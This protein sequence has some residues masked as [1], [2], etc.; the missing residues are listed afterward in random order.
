M[1][2]FDVTNEDHLALLPSGMR[3]APDLELLAAEAEADIVRFYTRRDR[4]PVAVEDYPNSPLSFAS[5]TRTSTEIGTD[6]GI[7]VYLLGY[8]ADPDSVDS[9]TYPNFVT[10]LRRTIVSV[11]AWRLQQA[12]RGLG[13]VS[14][15]TAGGT[16]RAFRADADSPF[17]PNWDRWL[18]VYDN[19][20]PVWGL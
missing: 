9:T 5:F 13:V 14:E 8:A 4:D 6:S 16:S 1:P 15:M 20:E 19:R 18:R 2:Y 3:D 17:P 7:R 11:V 10:D 12:K